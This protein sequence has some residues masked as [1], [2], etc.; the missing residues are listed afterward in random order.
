MWLRP[1]LLFIPAIVKKPGKARAKT[2]GQSCFAGC[3]SAP[4]HGAPP[5][6]KPPRGFGI[7]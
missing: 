6:N 1:I 3:R 7:A 4:M 5:A 2:R